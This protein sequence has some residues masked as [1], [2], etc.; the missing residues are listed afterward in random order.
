MEPTQRV[1]NK[2]EPHATAVLY[3]VDGHANRARRAP[4]T[5]RRLSTTIGRDPK[6]A[7]LPLTDP[8]ISRA[9]L[10][11]EYLPRGD[12]FCVRDLGSANGTFVNGQ[13]VT[14]R[15]LAVNDVI[16]AGSTLMVLGARKSR[17]EGQALE[18]I[19]IVDGISGLSREAERLLRLIRLGERVLLIGEAGVGKATIVRRL[20]ERLKIGGRVVRVGGALFSEPGWRKLLFGAGSERGLL[21]E[22][23]G[24]LLHVEQFHLIPVEA[25]EQLL[26]TLRHGQFRRTDSAEQHAFDAT[27]VATTTLHPDDLP[28]HARVV[29]GFLAAVTPPQVYLRPLRERRE[30]IAP[31][32]FAAMHAS[33][34]GPLPRFS[35]ELLEKLLLHRWPGNLSALDRMARLLIGLRTEDGEL[36]PTDLPSDFLTAHQDARPQRPLALD[37]AQVKTALIEHQGNVSRVAEALQV[38]RKRLYRAFSRMGIVA[39]DYRVS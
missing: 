22:A 2:L 7:D 38:D 18:E 12:R 32:L 5:L 30:D 23:N 27:V 21:D 37:E 36:T 39:S 11:L 14:E 16:R 35:I 4:V 28:G 1:E 33:T 6:R 34:S 10:E 3:V 19:G 15:E 17:L 29:P 20:A 24:G 26:S 13:R 8:A 31:Q 9:H 25:Q